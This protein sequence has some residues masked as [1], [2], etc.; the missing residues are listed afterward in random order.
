MATK[1]PDVL[2][3]VCP[4][5]GR[6]G[7]QPGQKRKG[8]KSYQITYHCLGGEIQHSKTAMKMVWF[9]PNTRRKP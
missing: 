3:P 5:C 4:E 9:E 7:S 8:K 1:P 2:L 6:V